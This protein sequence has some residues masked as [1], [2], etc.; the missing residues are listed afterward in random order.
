LIKQNSQHNHHHHTHCEE[1]SQLKVLEKFI[2]EF[3]SK[4]KALEDENFILN[5]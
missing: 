5:Q 3:K 1:D 4:I 2:T